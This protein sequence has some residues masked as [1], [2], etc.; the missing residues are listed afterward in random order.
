VVYF[1]YKRCSA[2]TLG[3]KDGKIV[4]EKLWEQELPGDVISSPLLAGGILFVATAGPVELLAL[5]ARTGEVLLEKELDLATNLYPSLA[6]AGGRLYLS[7]DQGETLVLE[8]GHVYKE[9]RHNRMLQGSGASPAFAGPHLFLRCG[10]T[11]TCIGP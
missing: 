5:N 10:E 11:L 7:N 9:L 1:A 8:P 4:A 2:L 6:L 3:L